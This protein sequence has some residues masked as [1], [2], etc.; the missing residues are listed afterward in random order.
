MYTKHQQTYFTDMSEQAYK[1]MIRMRK[2]NWQAIDCINHCYCTH[3][4]KCQI[5][6]SIT[7]HRHTPWPHT[8]TAKNKRQRKHHTTN[9]VQPCLNGKARRKEQKGSHALKQISGNEHI[10]RSTDTNYCNAK[11]GKEKNPFITPSNKKQSIKDESAPKEGK[12]KPDGSVAVFRQWY[13]FG[14][15]WAYEDGY[16]V[17]QCIKS[18]SP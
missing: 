9:L 14:R 5:G 6:I 1:P 4:I 3:I 2:E 16:K 7:Y 13:G 17:M 15:T 18:T 8:Q 10:T 12:Q 11:G